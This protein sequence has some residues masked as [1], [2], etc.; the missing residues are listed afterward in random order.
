MSPAPQPGPG[1]SPQPPTPQPPQPSPSPQPAP[2][3]PWVGFARTTT[4]NVW[5]PGRYAIASLRNLTAG[6]RSGQRYAVTC[7]FKAETSRPLSR[8]WYY[9][10]Y[11]LKGYHG[12]AAGI[13]RATIYEDDGNGNPR[14]NGTKYG[15]FTR[16]LRPLS[17][18]RDAMYEDIVRNARDLRAGS[19][20]HVTF[21]NDDGTNGNF[22]SVNCVQV[23]AYTRHTP[24]RWTDAMEYGCKFSTNNGSSWND[25]TR[26]NSSDTSEMVTTPMLR[27]TDTAGVEYGYAVLE[28]GAPDSRSI[29]LNQS[30]GGSQTNGIREAMF[31][32]KRMTVKGLSFIAE[33]MNGG[34]KLTITI[35]KLAGDGQSNQTAGQLW[36]HTLTAPSRGARD[37]I[38]GEREG[39]A[40]IEWYDIPFAQD[41]TLDANQWIAIDFTA[42]SGSWRF[43][44][45]TNCRRRGTEGGGQP[46]KMPV[47]YIDGEARYLNAGGNWIPLNYHAPQSPN[48][49]RNDVNWRGVALHYVEPG[50]GGQPASPPPAQPSPSPAQPSPP[51]AQPSPA[52]AQP[53]PAPA[54]P[55]QPAPG[56]TPGG[57]FTSWLAKATALKTAPEN[58]VPQVQDY[59][60]TLA[61]SVSP[62]PYYGT[63][64]AKVTT[65]V[66][67]QAAGQRWRRSDYSRRQAFNCDNTKFLMVR[68]DGYWF[69]HD[70]Q[71]LE[72][73]ATPL[74]GL[75]GDCEPIWHPTNPDTL[76]FIGNYGYGMKLRELNVKTRVE[77]PAVDLG[78]RL[79]AIW[80]TAMR[81]WSKS[82]GAPSVDGRYWCWM[83]ET[84]GYQIL[85]VVVYDRE[86]DKFLGHINT[87]ARP[88]HTSMSPSG[89]YATVS[90]AGNATLGTRAYT[91]NMTDPHPASPDGQPW[92][93]LHKQSEHSDLAL[94]PNGQD[95]YVFADYQSGPGEMAM[96][97]LHTGVR[98]SLFN[99]YVDGTSTAYHVSAR[100][101]KIPGYAVVSTYQEKHRDNDKVNL[102]NKPNM[103][104]FHRKVFVM[105]LEANPRFWPLAWADSDRLEAWGEAGYWAEPHATVNN[106]L[107]RVL[108]NSTMNQSDWKRFET[109]MLA[110]PDGTFPR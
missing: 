72:S 48:G 59:T 41:I 32:S 27:F 10:P 65:N 70:A 107:T 85:G 9:V 3:G 2:S 77:S 67:D 76:W 20:Y 83:V 15:E 82:E 43:A 35:S 99:T 42:P 106:T 29:V 47:S 18:D 39:F 16:D 45:Q 38:S 93:M 57:I 13:L 21:T 74:P 56:A 4:A 101:T 63:P 69:M 89:Q 51:P 91:R 108:F 28:S 55:A 25:L 80:P 90:W 22:Y 14:M 84:D 8:L 109:F 104:W 7:R 79:K 66:E 52:P 68:E 49:N 102:R 98:T 12:G 94:L 23:R 103:K 11:G 95:A 53:A 50:A 81:C 97:N 110:L 46:L 1:P 88:D 33:N 105:T 92:I 60:G 17:H 40:V 36:T 62:A 86:Q 58:P 26:P 34:D 44:G 96:V 54:Q 6:L 100:C 19:I 61:R 5:G 31:I 71:T 73:E 24:V 64:M 87:D 75:A 30:R 78:P 37:R